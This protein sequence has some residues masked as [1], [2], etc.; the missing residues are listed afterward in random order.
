MDG[1]V[2]I[3]KLDEKRHDQHARSLAK[4][5]PAYQLEF[6]NVKKAGVESF[7]TNATNEEI[8]NQ[9]TSS[10]IIKMLTIRIKRSDKLRI[11]NFNEK[12]K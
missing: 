5:E 2:I 8:R 3:V 7:A 12:V 11:F 4:T 1:L 9:A 10:R 6:A